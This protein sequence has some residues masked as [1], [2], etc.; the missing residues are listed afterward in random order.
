MSREP[1]LDS[2]IESRPRFCLSTPGNSST[3]LKASE[4]PRVAPWPK[5]P[6]KPIIPPHLGLEEQQP[7]ERITIKEGH[8]AQPPHTQTV[9]GK[10]KGKATPRSTP[11]LPKVDP[12]SPPSMEAL[13]A[14]SHLF[15]EP[16]LQN[17]DK[18]MV[19]DLAAEFEAPMIKKVLYLLWESTPF[20]MAAAVTLYSWSRLLFLEFL[21]V[22]LVVVVF[23]FLNGTCDT[24][25]HVRGLYSQVL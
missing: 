9:S 16:L 21:F 22:S 25:E 3:A 13:M 11:T 23:F 6:S 14:D 24:D 18:E 5:N 7:Q 20:Q 12:P 10:G 1:S 4:V 17:P 15:E 2:L 19:S 8:V